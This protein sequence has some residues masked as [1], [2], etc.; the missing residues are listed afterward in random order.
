[1]RPARNPQPPPTSWQFTW[2]ALI[3]LLAIDTII[4]LSS[5]GAKVYRC[6][7]GWTNLRDHLV[8]RAVLSVVAAC[9]VIG[10]ALCVIAE[11]RR[12]RSGAVLA[13]AAAGVLTAG[14]VIGVNAILR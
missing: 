14:T 7:D 9:I 12:R 5:I 6:A 1:M 11:D 13:M 2:I 3:A 8:P 10:G 4:V